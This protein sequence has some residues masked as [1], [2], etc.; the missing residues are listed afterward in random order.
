MTSLRVHFLPALVTPDELAGAA[1]VVVDVLRATTVITH[2]LAAGAREVIPC[3]EVD[4]AMRAVAKLPAGQAVLGG[5]RGGLKIE[6]FDLGNSPDE[7]TSASVGGRTLVFTTTNGTRAMTHARLARR[8]LIGAFANGSAVVE[9]L[10]DAG[11]V[12]L[13]CAGTR[14]EITRED[15]LFAGFVADGLLRRRTEDESSVEINDQLLLAR[16]AWR[17]FLARATGSDL[18]VELAAELRST[19]GG[20]NLK[21]IGLEHDI[22]VA[23]QLDRFK[24]VPELDLPSWKITA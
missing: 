5:E 21:K 22:D 11:D 2:A 18:S 20:R 10:A 4:D 24:I 1:V 7:F 3:L 12:R 19:Q 15:V 9:S 6:G 23:A 14:G 16:D 17:A 13:L 8:V